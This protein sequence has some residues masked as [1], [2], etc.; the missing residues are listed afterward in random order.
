LRKSIG[1]ACEEEQ[2]DQSENE[3]R[4]F[5]FYVLIRL[6]GSECSALRCRG[7]MREMD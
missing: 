3:E 4:G 5:H 1:G 7:S 2:S 6:C